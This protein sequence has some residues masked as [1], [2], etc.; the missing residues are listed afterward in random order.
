M[1]DEAESSTRTLVMTEEPTNIT[2]SKTARQARLSGSAVAEF[3]AA[4]P[5]P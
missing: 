1:G 3:L 2:A 4:F 5:A